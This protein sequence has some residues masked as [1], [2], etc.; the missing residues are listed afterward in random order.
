MNFTTERQMLISLR[1]ALNS[2]DAGE[3]GATQVLIKAVRVILSAADEDDT[4]RAGLNVPGDLRAL[5]VPSVWLDAFVVGY[6][7]PSMPN[8]DKRA[9]GV[10]IWE[11]STDEWK[12]ARTSNLAAFG[13]SDGAE[14][15]AAYE[16]MDRIR[17]KR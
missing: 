15:L 12:A 8:N 10:G 3:P 5:Q 9:T 11:R 7:V 16:R 14:L 4:E 2:V 17:A 13:A 6:N 1:T